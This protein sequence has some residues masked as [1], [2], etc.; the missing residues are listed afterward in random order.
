[1]VT[2]GGAHSRAM[3]AWAM[4]GNAKRWWQ[5]RK[6]GD[7]AAVQ[8]ANNAPPGKKQGPPLCRSGQI[9]TCGASNSA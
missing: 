5:P 4:V 8:R 3:A 1:M 9:A 7:K 6:G 2:H